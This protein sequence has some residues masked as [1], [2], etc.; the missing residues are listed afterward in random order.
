M[1]RP[2]LLA[3]VLWLVVAPAAPVLAHAE[4]AGSTPEEGER[5]PRVPTSLAITFTEPPTG[6]AVVEVSDGCGRDVVSDVQVQNLEITAA[7]AEG[8]PGKWTVHTN[9]ISGID[10]HNTRDRWSFT[11]RGEPDCAA[12]ETIAPDAA[13]D[14]DDEGGGSPVALIAIGAAT[15]A[16]VALGL[17]LRGRGG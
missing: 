11:V 16:L 12:A 1:T 3:A 13:G 5:V 15:L 6:D 10:G 4:R 17:V 9:V 8:R 7:L 2:A 14:E